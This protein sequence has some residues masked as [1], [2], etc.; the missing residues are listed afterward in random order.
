MA[1]KNA[2]RGKKLA[3]FWLRLVCFT[4]LAVL[5]LT[6]A[7]YVLTPKNEYGI[8]SMVNYYQQ[9]KDSIDV[10]VIGTSMG[11]AGI[12]TN[13]LWEEFGIA[14]YILCS[15]EQPFWISYYT[16]QE[17]LKTQ[18]P[19]VILLDAKPAM[20][21]LDYSKRGR[22]ILSTYGIKSIENRAG[23]IFACTETAEKA[24][25]FILG[26]PEVH[27]NYQ[28]VTAEDFVF[29][30]TNEGRGSTWK[31]YIEND[32][33]ESH[34]KPSLVYNDVRRNINAREEEYVRKIFEYISTETDIPMIVIGM[35]N[36]DYAN[37]HMY[38]NYLWAVA[39]EYKNVYWVNYNDPDLRYGLR[40]TSDFADWQH[41]NVKGSITFTRKLGADLKEWFRDFLPDHRGDPYYASYDECAR[42]W[43][44]IYDTFES[45]EAE[46][47]PL[48]WFDAEEPPSDPP[49]E[50]PE[51]FDPPID[52]FEPPFEEL[53]PPPEGFE[54]GPEGF[55]PPPE[56]FEPPMEEAAG[57]AV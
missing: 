34:Q 22:V 32:V 48:N 5:V 15:A 38:Y 7:T 41:L 40:Y 27:S 3:A 28:K 55:E 37:D 35:P 47:H 11:Y 25:N 45:A 20:Y 17:A 13:V 54:E 33:V 31:G 30:P 51:D 24:W 18:H 49:A 36:P 57:E 8:C 1:A 2:S 19:K 10:L 42:I 50:L 26:L 6:Y 43:Y 21:N 23:A 56:G 16:L 14:S 29:P 12:N 4:V 44:D 52:A 9:P 46:S 53:A 39:E